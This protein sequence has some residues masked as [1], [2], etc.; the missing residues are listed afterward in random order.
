MKTKI[1]TLRL[2]Q[3]DRQ[4]LTYAVHYQL[5]NLS[6]NQAVGEVGLLSLP[7]LQ[8]KGEGSYRIVR[9]FRRIN[10][11]KAAE[12]HGFEGVVIE[13]NRSAVDLL[14]EAVFDNLDRLHPVDKALI[15]G[16]L[17]G[18]LPGEGIIRRFFASLGLH[19][20]EGNL[21]RQLML[22]SLE[23]AVK[24]SMIK[25]LIHETAAVRLSRLP[26]GQRP[27]LCQLLTSL[28]LSVSKQ[29]EII[30]QMGELAERR[31][32][33][34]KEIVATAALQK[35]LQD[36]RLS[37]PQ[38]A[39]GVRQW[40][41]NELQ[42]ALSVYEASFEQKRKKISL[43]RKVRLTAPPYFEGS[44]FRIDFS[45]RSLEEFRES[46]E[47]LKKAADRRELEDILCLNLF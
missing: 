2:N 9:G 11:L 38:K 13:E 21:E 32:T 7:A 40:L 35:I 23:P 26:S 45:C 43:N 47:I 12:I 15:V 1:K 39:E 36:D 3:V 16:K 25:G 46:V 42:P 34:V 22:D 28:R 20:T 17:S 18:F 31:E 6:L 24:D 44:D 41:K 29:L 14:T 30:E 10:A 5:T 37:L 19:P 8:E 27:V 33:T 4:D